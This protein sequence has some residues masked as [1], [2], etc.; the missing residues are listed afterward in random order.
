MGV[1][2][3]YS[4]TISTGDRASTRFVPPSDFLSR[5]PEPDRA[6]LQAIARSRSFGKNEFVFQAASPGS[7]V[8][9]LTKGRVKIY[10][11]SPVGKKSILWFCFPGEM[12]GLAE[13]ARNQPYEV[14]AQTCT[15]SEVLAVDQKKFKIFL[16]VH[17]E[18]AVLMIDLLAYRLR[19][20]GEMLLNVSSDDVTIRVI[21]LI[22]RLNALYGKKM[23]QEMYLDIHLTHEE[24]ADMVSTSRQTV[25]TILGS[26]QR[27]GMLRI[28]DHTIHIRDL[29][30]LENL[31]SNAT[32]QQTH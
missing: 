26:L 32:F 18:T 17:P 1:Q 19:V 5:I 28:E 16:A 14:F 7:N 27:N 3:T 15:D 10:Q 6:D 25:T 29:E 13:V 2:L 4:D 23:D 11:L 22:T 20:L 12:F 9:I 21:K 8:Y 24:M 30:G 31:I